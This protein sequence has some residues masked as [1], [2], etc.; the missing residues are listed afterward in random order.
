MEETGSALMDSNFP[1]PIV[2]RS[3]S[4]NAQEWKRQLSPKSPRIGE[5]GFMSLGR[6]RSLPRFSPISPLATSPMSSLPSPSPKDF[7]MQRDVEFEKSLFPSP[8]D[9]EGPQDMAVTRNIDAMIQ[10]LDQ[11][12]VHEF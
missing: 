6:T 9:Q 5:L 2:T 4:L 12:L 8:K 7:R 10:E 1:F 11:L 3:Q